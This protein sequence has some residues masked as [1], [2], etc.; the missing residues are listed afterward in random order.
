MPIVQEDVMLWS[1]VNVPELGCVEESKSRV[2]DDAALKVRV[3]VVCLKHEELSAAGPVHWIA[4][5]RWERETLIWS[6][7]RKEKEKQGQ[8]IDEEREREK[9]ETKT[10]KG[11]KK[12]DINFILVLSTFVNL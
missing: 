2:I 7:K 11:K 8:R 3:V 9:R 12:Q 4:G 1:M 5:L 10:K 6:R